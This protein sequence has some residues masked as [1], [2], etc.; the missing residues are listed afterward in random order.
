MPEIFGPR[1]IERLEPWIT[2]DLELFA[3]AFGAMFDPI[4]EL[5]EETGSDGE[6][7]YVPAWGILFEVERATLREL[8]FLSNFVGVTVPKGATEAE[9]RALV[10]ASAGLERGTLMSLEGVIKRII[11]A[12]EPFTIQERT[13]ASGEPAAYYFNVYVPTGKIS[14]AL[15]N[16]INEVIPA[17]I[18]YTLFELK[19]AW[20]EG[21]KAWENI[22]AGK[23]WPEMTEGNY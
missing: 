7:G 11:G 20:L 13:N 5:A 19:E 6:A 21:K 15:Y 8:P 4:L 12:T 1:L 18:W 14:Q 22:V 9:A 2:P 10:K 3:K 16:A 23:K 17:G